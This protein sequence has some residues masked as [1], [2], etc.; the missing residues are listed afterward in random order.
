MGDAFGEQPVLGRHFVLRLDHQRFVDQRGR[1]AVGALHP[2]DDA[3]ETVERADGNL[4]RD[5]A[6]RRVR[7]DIV[8]ASEPGRIFHLTE[9]RQRM[10]PGCFGCCGSLSLRGCDQRAARC[11]DNYRRGCDRGASLQKT[12][13]GNAQA[14]GLVIVVSGI[15]RD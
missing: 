15:V 9:Q 5:A 7:I 1:A 10:I 11:R 2:G 14:A 8:E 6:L 13:S 3:V 4:P 12:S